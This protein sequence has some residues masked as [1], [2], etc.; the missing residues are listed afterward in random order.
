MGDEVAFECARCGHCC[1]QRL[2]LLNTE[3]IFRMAEHL[4]MSVPQFIERYSVV[5]ARAGGNK[6]PRLYLQING[7]SCPFFADG[8]IVHAFKPLMCRLFPVLKPGQT[9]EEIKALINKHAVS[10]GVRHCKIFSVPGHT[11]MAVDREAMITSVIYDSVETI[12]YSNLQ[13]TD[14]KFIYTL[15]RAVNKDQLRA[16]VRDYL[17]NGSTESGLIFEQAM[18]EIQAMCQVIDWKKTP[19]IVV[20]DGAS[21]EPGRIMVYVS[22]QDARDVF[23]ASTG[24][25]IEA[26]FSQANPSV[27]DPS[28]AFVSVAIRLKGD[29]GMLLAFGG[30]KED[31]REV[32]EDGRATLGFCPSDGSMDEVGA[33][34]VFID[35]AVIR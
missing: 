19:Y 21:F 17:F 31:L 9:A 34:N 29:R 8:C 25:Q 16:I 13:R 24:G 2:I 5:F 10:D 15:L 7:Q 11:V 27:A 14:M 23:E 32:T 20:N 28:C 18:F 1:T 4:K 3:D 30:R 26:V 35:P 6:S 33:L 22:P 12:Y